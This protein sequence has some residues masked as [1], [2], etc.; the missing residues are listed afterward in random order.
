M[1]ALKPSSKA[2]G[3]CFLY[4]VL[5]FKLVHFSNSGESFSELTFGW[6]NNWKNNT[7]TSTVTVGPNPK[8]NLWRCLVSCNSSSSF[9]P[10]SC[11]PILTLVEDKDTEEA[12]LRA[13]VTSARKQSRSSLVP[14][15]WSRQKVE[16][17]FN[18]HPQRIKR[19]LKVRYIYVIPWYFCKPTGYCFILRKRHVNVELEV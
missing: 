9:Q 1:L 15:Q 13:C 8:S 17:D 10:R 19:V 2:A 5:P 7:R 6:L 18:F 14:F 11:V 16:R 12:T 4:H 3:V